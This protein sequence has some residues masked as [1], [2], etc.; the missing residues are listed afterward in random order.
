M[1]TLT[2]PSIEYLRECFDYDPITGKLL[3]KQRPQSHFETTKEWKRW[4]ARYA[5]TDAGHKERHSRVT[6]TIGSFAV[7][8]VIWKLMTEKEPPENIDHKNRN[9]NDNVWKNLREADQ[10]KQNWNK[11]A[12]R[13]NK[14][15]YKGVSLDRNRWR[16]VIQVGKTQ[17]HLGM[18][19]TAE[20]AAAVY[21]AAARELHGEFYREDAQ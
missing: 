7:H 21:R 6:F 9:G 18:F 12:T 14:S 8:R 17:R 19:S 3:W 2:L 5:G 1:P 16:A 20:E 4:N 15:G 11:P 10:T 13:N